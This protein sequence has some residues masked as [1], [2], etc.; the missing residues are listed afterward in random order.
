MVF[1]SFSEKYTFFRAVDSPNPDFT[2]CSSQPIHH[3]NYNSSM[4]RSWRSETHRM[5]WTAPPPEYAV[6]V[7]WW[8][9][10]YRWPSVI[11][12]RPFFNTL[13]CHS[14]LV[15]LLY[16]Y[17]RIPLLR[18]VGS[19]FSY[20]RVRIAVR[21][22]LWGVYWGEFFVL[23]HRIGRSP[24]NKDDWYYC[25][26]LYHV[27]LYSALRRHYYFIHDTQDVSPWTVPCWI[28]IGSNEHWHSQG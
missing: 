3:H 26:S 16:S 27:V 6:D 7:K 19:Y 21:Y 9:C 24:S 18:I 20:G 12:D 14:H 25:T 10:F 11:V 15:S 2:S 1:L 23:H 17:R 5:S 13:R 28:T 8:Y 22:E 4:D